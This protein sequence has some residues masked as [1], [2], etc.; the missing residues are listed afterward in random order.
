MNEF[1]DRYHKP[2]FIVENGLGA[3]DEVKDNQIH[4]QYRIDY[5]QQ[6]ITEAK[7]AIQHSWTL[8]LNQW[9]PKLNIRLSSRHLELLF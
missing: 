6:H 5:L 1:W 8:K 3:V 7:K 4:D 9:D 2:L